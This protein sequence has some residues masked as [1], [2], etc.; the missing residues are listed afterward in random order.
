MTIIT[1]PFP[2]ELR[3]LTALRAFAALLVVM[4]HF[5]ARTAPN[6]ALHTT[7]IDNGQLGVDIFFVLSGF[8][9]AHVYLGRF[10]TQRFQ[11]VDF[12]WNRF[13]RLYPMHVLMLLAALSNGVLAMRHGLP[14]NVYGPPMGL[15]PVTGTGFGW[16]L[17][18]NLALVHAWGTTNGYYFNAVS[19]SISAETF[20][21]LAFPLIAAVC[22]AFGQRPLARLAAVLLFFAACEGL[23]RLILGVG[24][25]D[26]SWRFGILRIIPEF[27][28]GVAFYGLGTAWKL[29]KRGLTWL[30][31]LVAIAVLAMLMAGAPLA[32]MPPVFGALILLLAS[33]E[34]QGL[35]PPE[36]LLRPLVY[37]G[38]ISYSTYMLHLLLGKVYFNAIARLFGYD[39]HALPVAQ[40]LLAVI[41]MLVASAITY[42]CVEQPGRHLLKAA[43]NVFLR[44]RQVLTAH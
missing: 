27:A 22:L 8:I 16:N 11:L 43:R 9:L 2:A 34:R 6:S 7:L 28:L 23:S 24:L 25:N 12:L 14:L 18:T 13:A 10:E 37:L 19:W 20:A 33:S 42:Y 44:P 1:H 3:L 36:W 21:Y 40:V 30:T 35:T 31:P 17:F 41:P 39:P 29:P 15:D 26:L 38:E 5:A 32:L 4:F